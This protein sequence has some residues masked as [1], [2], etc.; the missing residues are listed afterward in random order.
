MSML[1]DVN[2]VLHVFATVSGAQPACC[3]PLVISV[4]PDSS[5]FHWLLFE[6]CIQISIALT[7]SCQKH[8][9]CACGIALLDPPTQKYLINP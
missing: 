7:S 5:Q 6:V 3:I 8:R 4:H 1:L 9:Q 2:K